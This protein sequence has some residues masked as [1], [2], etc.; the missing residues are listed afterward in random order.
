[1]LVTRQ[2]VE[3]VQRRVHGKLK[4]GG[5]TDRDVDEYW[6]PSQFPDVVRAQLQMLREFDWNPLSPEAVASVSVRTLVVFG[7]LDRTV[8]PANAAALVAQLPHGRLAW[9]EGGGHV[10]MEE[11]PDRINRLLTDFLANESD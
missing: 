8:R 10:V 4:D 1:M 5:F 9:V 6:A 2:I 11:V 3:V 7:T